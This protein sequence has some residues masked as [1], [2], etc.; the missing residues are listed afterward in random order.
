[1]NLKKL[2]LHKETLCTLSA[3]N[4]AKVVGGFVIGGEETAKNTLCW[5][6]PTDTMHICDK[7]ISDGPTC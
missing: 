5:C 7:I 1:M 2:S 3:S 4:S 6:L